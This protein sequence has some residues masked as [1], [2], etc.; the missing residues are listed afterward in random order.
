MMSIDNHVHA[1]ESELAKL[2]VIKFGYK[3]EIARELVDIIKEN[4]KNG[5]TADET[6]KR[7]QLMIG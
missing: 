5:S 7:A 3:S 4:I 2:F 1:S 6:M